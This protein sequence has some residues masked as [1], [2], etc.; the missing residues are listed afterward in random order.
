[1]STVSCF[2]SAQGAHFETND[3]VKQDW[4]VFENENQAELIILISRQTNRSAVRI[5]LTSRKYIMSLVK[6]ISLCQI[7][8][9]SASGYR[10][11]K[12]HKLV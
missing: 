12:N 5:I 3:V 2:L 7:H 6:T 8:M 9:Q 4:V 10:I 1:M 11:V